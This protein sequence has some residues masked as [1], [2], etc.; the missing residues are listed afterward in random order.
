MRIVIKVGGSQAFTDYGPNKAYLERLIPVLKGIG[1]RHQLIVC[2]GGGQFIRKY[3]KDVKNFALKN[4]E[5]EW[6]F[7]DLLKTNVRLFSFL[8]KKRPIYDLNDVKE[9][10]E[11]VVGGIEPGRSTDANAA[12]CAE[13]I[14]AD[15]FIKL[16]DVDGIYDKDPK[17]YKEAKRI[18]RIKFSE[19]DKYMIK[20]KPASYGVLDSL[21]LK[22]IRRARIKT[23]VINGNNPNNILR[24]LKGDKIGTLIS[25]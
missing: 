19:I 12:L 17:K 2:I 20:G 5:I 4:E 11:G 21:A 13:K 1:K 24:V 15:L 16:T 3:L 10:T 8:L 18:S 25:H 6:L 14:K 7:V 22:V 23:I 9:D